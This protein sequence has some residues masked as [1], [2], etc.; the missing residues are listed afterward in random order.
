MEPTTGADEWVPGN[1]DP[2]YLIKVHEKHLVWA[3]FTTLQTNAQ[4]K[5]IQA[6]YEQSFTLQMWQ[7]AQE[8]GRFAGYQVTIL[9]HPTEVK[10]TYVSPELEEARKRFRDQTGAEADPTYTLDTLKGIFAAWATYGGPT[11]PVGTGPEPGPSQLPAGTT[12][13]AQGEQHGSGLS[14]TGTGGYD[15][16][17]GSLGIPGGQADSGG[18]PPGSL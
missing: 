2:S 11:R 7:L 17:S 4:G 3:R 1:H 15:A 10:R 16:G 13:A 14:A 6:P 8:T 9:N 5:P 18:L 12:V